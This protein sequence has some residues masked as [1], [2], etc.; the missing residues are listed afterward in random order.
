MRFAGSAVKETLTFNRG[1]LRG[2]V[3]VPGDKSI[4]HRALI[5]GAAQS[6]PLRLQNLNS[7]SDVL[8]TADALRKLGAQISLN[9][10][11]GSVHATKLHDA[12][13]T[14]ECRNS[15]S[16]ARMVLGVCAGANLRAHF[17]GDQ[18]LRSRPMEPVAGQLRA[19]GALIE[20]Q[21]GCLP[22]DIAGTPQVQTRDFILLSPSAQ[23]KSALIF[24]A[25]FAKTPIS[26]T[27]DAGSRN[28]TERMLEGFGAKIRYDRRAV[29]FEPSELTPAPLQ[30]PGD[31]SAAA[32]FIVGAAICPGS[33]IVIRDVG[34]NPTRTGLLDA[35][36]A[37]GASISIS[38]QREWNNEPVADIE[39]KA[40]TLRGASIG[41]EVAARAL[42]EIPVLAIAAA[43]ARGVT[44]IST[45]QRLKEKESDRLATVAQMLERVGIAREVEADNISIIGNADARIAQPGTIATGG[46]H[47]IAMSAA[48]LAAV[49]G[50]IEIDDASVTDI[51]FPNFVTTWAAVQHGT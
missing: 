33:S 25:L 21:H 5:I 12:A 30:I 38:N 14:L 22:I 2:E 13:D 8:A 3:R 9:G 20:T 41:T 16:T 31:F 51:S 40:G 6:E 28:H 18:S 43:Y 45:L 44:R 11:S 1:P 39:V 24:A 48:P 46:D 50:P 35:L 37:M 36:E 29:A 4:S 17:D 32:F 19:F 10:P 15:G 23:I 26:I 27:N 49:M 34:V 47:R 42:D 7:G